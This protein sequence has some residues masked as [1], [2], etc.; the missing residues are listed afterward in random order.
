MNAP[1]DI[2]NTP[3]E[4][5]GETRES[6]IILVFNLKDFFISALAFYN[7]VD[8]VDIDRLDARDVFDLNDMD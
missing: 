1:N 2:E 7:A 8:I 3:N 4:A 5:T 6:P